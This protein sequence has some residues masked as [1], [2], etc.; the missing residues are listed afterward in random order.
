MGA[1]LPQATP[2]RTLRTVKSL[3]YG[4]KRSAY[5]RKNGVDVAI[6]WSKQNRGGIRTVKTSCVLG[7]EKTR[8]DRESRLRIEERRGRVP[9]WTGRQGKKGYGK[10]HARMWIRLEGEGSLK[11]GGRVGE[12]VSLKA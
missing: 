4:E 11:K 3:T 8:E 10:G 12:W 1:S 7:K 9:W 6:S 5:S 2:L